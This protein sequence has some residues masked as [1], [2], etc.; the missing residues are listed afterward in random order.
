[1]RFLL[2]DSKRTGRA[3][4]SRMFQSECTPI[5]WACGSR[6]SGDEGGLWQRT[7]RWHLNCVPLSPGF[8]VTRTAGRVREDA[9]LKRRVE[10]KRRAQNLDSTIR[11]GMETARVLYLPKGTSRLVQLPNPASGSMQSFVVCNDELYELR[12]V[13]GDNPHDKQNHLRPTTK[14]DSQTVR[15]LILEGPDNNGFIIEN[16]ALLVATKFNPSFLLIGYFTSQKGSRFQ[17][18]ED[19]FDSMQEVTPALNDLPETLIQSALTT[20]CETVVEGDEPF[21]KFSEEITLAWLKGRVSQLISN[22]PQTILESL[23]KPLLYPV[24]I[25]DTIP[26][27][28]MQLALRKFSI[29]LISSY[30]TA[31]W[32]DRLINEYD[33]VTLDEYI[34]RTQQQRTDK[35]AAQEN[36]SDINHLNAQNKRTQYDTKGPLKKK[37]VVKRQ[38]KVSTGALDM[39]FKKKAT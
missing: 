9:K 30:L 35:R 38:V 19:L 5:P 20:I 24:G 7:A 4:G 10:T 2:R 34:Q 39:F 27:E 37:A 33:F 8:F 22:F 13:D 26:A 29:M 18:S 14:K 31:E 15:S 11:A 36:L 32:N 3:D 25:D 17:S 23:V 1:M 21:Y 12:E 6:V 16:G 28:V